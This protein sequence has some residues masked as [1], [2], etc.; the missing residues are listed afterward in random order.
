MG[1]FFTATNLKKSF[2]DLKSSSDFSVEISFSCEQKTM[3]GIVGQSGSGKSTILRM[4]AGLE[5]ADAGAKIELDGKNITNEPPGKREIGFVFQNGALFDHLRVVDNVAYG[6]VAR[7]IPKKIAHQKASEFLA[8]FGMNGFEKRFPDTLSGGEAQRVSLAR[9][10]ILNPKLVLFDEP[11]SALDA[12]LRKKAAEEIKNL[13][14]EF[15]FTGIIVTHD[16]DE[17]KTLCQKII[18]IK[19]GKIAWQGSSKDFG[20]E[21][22]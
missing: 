4:I 2:S 18:L 16:I 22:Y 5:K 14:A 12:P 9:T 3:T 15:G 11:L 20:I 6:L 8:R 13:Q 1:D 7:K 17:A 10:L 21:R 19:N